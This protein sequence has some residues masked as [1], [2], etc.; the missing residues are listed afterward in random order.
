MIYSDG[1]AVRGERGCTP[2]ELQLM[3]HAQQATAPVG[4]EDEVGES[5]IANGTLMIGIGDV[6]DQNLDKLQDVACGVAPM[7]L[8]PKW[9][10][11][12]EQY[13]NME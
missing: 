9:D 10:E 12:D 6:W 3:L 5:S 11:Q 2:E 7:S 8:M 4:L 1:S 13:F